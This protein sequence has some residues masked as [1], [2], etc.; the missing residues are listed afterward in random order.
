MQGTVTLDG[1]PL[2]EGSISFR[3]LRGT[4]SPT[5]G[6]SIKNGSFN[7]DSK[8]GLIA[9]IFRVEIMASRK[10]GKKVPDQITGGMVDEYEQYVPALYNTES[11]L[12][13]EVTNGGKN[14][15]SFVLES[16]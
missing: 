4:Q 6:A 11:T 14:E 1:E 13:E 2:A 5:A 8:V 3:P 12:I 10:T 16:K 7:I 15:F 9:G